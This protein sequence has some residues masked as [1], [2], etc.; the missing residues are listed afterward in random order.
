MNGNDLPAIRAQLGILWG[1]KRPLRKAELGRACGYT[2]LNAWRAVA[3]WESSDAELIPPVVRLLEAMLHAGYRPAFRVQR[4]ISRSG[5][6][7]D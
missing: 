6:K 4:K 1:L 5:I 7:T 2:K 3:R